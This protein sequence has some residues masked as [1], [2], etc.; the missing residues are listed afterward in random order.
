VY[1]TCSILEEENAAIVNAFLASHP[2]FSRLSASQILADQGIKLA[3][4][5]DL[6][7]NPAVHGTDGFYAAILQ[8]N[9]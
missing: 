9:A 3:T 4:G 6:L 7:L 1:A 5:E 8:R 2:E